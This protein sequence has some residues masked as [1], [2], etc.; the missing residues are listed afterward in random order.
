MSNNQQTTASQPVKKSILRWQGLAGFA[1][2]FI[3]I[4]LF[5]Y[6]FAGMLIKFS[7][8]KGL[9]WYLGAEVNVEQVDVQWSPFNLDIIGFQ[10]TDPEQPT[11][12]LVAFQQASAGIDFWQYLFGKTI[13][14]QLSINQLAL[15]SHRNTPGEV[16]NKSEI[17][18]PEANEQTS[19][20]DDASLTG[21]DIELPSTDTVL[22]DP[23]LKTP[24]AA[25]NLKSVYAAEKQKYQDLKS[26]IP[27]Q[28]TLKYYEQELKK[29]GD[30]KVKSL[31]DVEQLKQD[32]EK[33]KQQFKQ[34]KAAIKAAKEQLATSKSNIS[35]A[36]SE[37]KTAPKADWQYIEQ[38]YQLD[39]LDGGDVAHLLF[40]AKAREHYNTATDIYRR[41]KPLL[42][43]SSTKE[44]K[45]NTNAMGRFVH[46]TE[47]NPLPS[48]LVKSAKINIISPQGEFDLSINELT[49]EHWFRNLPT[50]WT[51]LSS[52]MLGSGQLNGEGK[53]R[54]SENG[55]ITSDGQW[56]L[57]QLKLDKLSLANSDSLQ[58]SLDSADLQGTGDFNLTNSQITSVAKLDIGNAQ[59]SG[60]ADSSLNRAV[61]NTIKGLSPL[62]LLVT[63]T[64][65]INDPNFSVRSKLD[66][67]LKDAAKQQV[68]AKLD[69]FK[70]SLQSKLQQQAAD[71]LNL[72]QQEANELAE[73]SQLLDDTDGKLDELL[74]SKVIDKHKDKLK[75]KVEDKLKKKL[76]KLFG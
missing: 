10:A 51:L 41:V 17:A 45:L 34:D 59:Y 22:N 23:N 11:Q 67:L 65:E 73:L 9:G 49:S 42:S 55:V 24:K 1:T 25:D 44:E 33:L 30:S 61:L 53:A 38:T 70:S 8:E 48:W 52:N 60:S 66:S 46:F 5:L 39:E 68:A 28:D 20:Q 29:L 35:Q 16:F 19:A 14:E 32:F 56:Q 58:L 6:V 76:G 2:T 18:K 71:S 31:E 74:K 27:N 47:R 43:Q 36:V 75:N 26:D 69:D 72:N 57:T 15:G 37:L 54:I 13:I 50:Q 7:I 3:F 64:G 4:G 63:V 12:N 40:G 62:D 21:M